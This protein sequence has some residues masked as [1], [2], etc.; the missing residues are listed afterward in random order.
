[1]TEPGR[2][3]IVACGKLGAV[4][5]LSDGSGV[6]PI[7]FDNRDLSVL[8]S[9]LKVITQASVHFSVL[10]WTRKQ[11]RCPRRQTACYRH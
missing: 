10:L 1:M 11:A 6:P 3:C 7:V 5:G 2:L 8:Q 4:I 9:F